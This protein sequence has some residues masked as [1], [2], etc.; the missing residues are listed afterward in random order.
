MKRN[1]LRLQNLINQILDISKLET[2]KIKL[3]VS[4][5]NLEKFVRTIISSFLSFAESKKIN[6]IYDLPETSGMVFFD[7]DKLERY[8]LI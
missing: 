4:E 7:G 1:T 5:G 3:Q 6:Y 2:G 8:L